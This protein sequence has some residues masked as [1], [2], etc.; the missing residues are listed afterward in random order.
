[1]VEN[2]EV[3]V[4][5][6]SFQDWNSKQNK[7]LGEKVWDKTKSIAKG[8]WN[9]VKKGASAVWSGAK[10]VG[11]GIIKTATAPLRSVVG[12]AKGAWNGAKNTFNAL[13]EGDFGGAATAAFD[14]ITEMAKNAFGAFKDTPFGKIATKAFDTVKNTKFG[15]IATK[16]FDTAKEHI[17]DTFKSIGKGFGK[18][19]SGI[20]SGFKSVAKLGKKAF[21]GVKSA[22]KGIGKKISNI[23]G[24]IK[25][26]FN[27]A[28][29]SIKNSAVGKAAKKVKDKV[30]S[31]AKKAWNGVKNFFTGGSGEGISNHRTVSHGGFGVSEA[32]KNA[33][34]KMNASTGLL[35][36]I[37]YTKSYSTD[38]LIK[39][40]AINTDQIVKLF[41]SSNIGSSV[42]KTFTSN[43]SAKERAESDKLRRK[44]RAANAKMRK[45]KKML[46]GGFGDIP[47][48]SQSDSRWGSDAYNMGQD[49]ATMADTGCGPT[50]M[51]MIASG[52]TGQDVTPP[53][54]ASLA[55][56]TGDR[57]ETGTNWNFI[58]KAAN[59]YG[60]NTTFLPAARAFIQRS[61]SL[62]ATTNSSSKPPT[63]WKSSAFISI[64]A[65]VT[66]LISCTFTALPKYPLSSQD[67]IHMIWPAIPPMPRTTPA[68]WM[69]LSG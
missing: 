36:N 27:D 66:A 61:M 37:D 5:Y 7:S 60:V 34:I 17:K 2:G 13:K 48:Y 6:D 22:F 19:I 57:D 11:K 69:R 14:G 26:K 53:E 30:K 20:K 46:T 59:A 49:D 12:V 23:F 40:I 43:N 21:N 32:I 31:T 58:G 33:A 29:E 25:D 1:M 50:A 18:A 8:A 10:K 3:E 38:D 16:A 47:V 54:M 28:A 55:E 68:C 35:Q 24:G 64:H 44:L 39:R 51:A 62:K 67:A 56:A 42:I 63:A 65:A 15:K 4:K 45:A 41:T 52:M 9:G